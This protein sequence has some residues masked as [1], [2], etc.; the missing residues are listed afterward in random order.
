MH[1]VIIIGAGCAG[2]TAAIY[3]ARADLQPLVFTGDLPG[4]QLTLTTQVENFPGFP[5]GIPGP[6]L[7]ARMEQQARRLGAEVRLETVTAVNFQEHPFTVTTA[8]GDYQ[9]QAVIVATGSSPRKLGIPGEQELLG[10]GVSYCAT[11]DGFFFRGQ[12]VAVVGGGD[13]AAEEATFLTRFA[14]KVYLIHRRDRLRASEALQ[15]RVFAEE[16]IEILWDTLVTA[17]LSGPEEKV[18][19]LRIKNLK[20]GEESELPLTGLFVAIG[21][22]PNTQIF[23]GQLELDGRGYIVTDRRC[24]TSVPGVFACGDVQDYRYQ[25]AVTAAGTGCMAALEAEQF[26]AELEQRAYPGRLEK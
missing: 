5:E 9:A 3:T 6:E 22:E 10:R 26:I 14:E 1:R 2:W 12:T 15:R 18:K 21:H 23:A 17:L 16:K 19:G 11:C 20:T 25:Q 8:Q 7:M 24:H 13:A 4:G